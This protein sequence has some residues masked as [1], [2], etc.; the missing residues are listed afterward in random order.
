MKYLLI[1]FLIL[2]ITFFVNGKYILEAR[3]FVMHYTWHH[4]VT[5]EALM[6]KEY[7][8]LLIII[9]YEIVLWKNILS[10]K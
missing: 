6:Q 5:I 1:L 4:A 3:L 10:H 7:N 2:N 8:I 9:K